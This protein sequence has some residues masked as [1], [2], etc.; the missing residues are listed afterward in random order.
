MAYLYCPKHE[1]YNNKERV[2]GKPLTK[3]T[4]LIKIINFIENI[5]NI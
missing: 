2:N 4:Y 1:K 5:I 3:T